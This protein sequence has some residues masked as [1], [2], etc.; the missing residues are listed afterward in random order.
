MGIFDR[1]FKREPA[2]PEVTERV[3]LTEA[4]KF[5]AVHR[6]VSELAR[7]HAAVAVVAHFPDT[8]DAF[9]NV[10]A[11][12]GVAVEPTRRIKG[13]ELA[14]LARRPEGSRVLAAIASGLE[15]DPLPQPATGARPVALLLLERHPLRA[16][17]DVVRDFA[18]GVG[19]DLRVHVSVEDA[20]L[21]AFSGEKTLQLLRQL[22]MNEQDAIE[23]PMIARAI[24]GAQKKFAQAA[25]G[26][27][28]ARSMAEWLRMNVPGGA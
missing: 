11:S 23:H 18:A 7:T 13:S 19:G 12:P 22:G 21:K 5:R 25:T 2:T 24:Q 27:R 16:K 8:L 20:L 9:L 3:W 6:E 17:D 4:A 28:A 26:D 1:L 14:A 10:T 15:F